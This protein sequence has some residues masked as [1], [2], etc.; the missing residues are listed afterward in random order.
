ME[1]KAPELTAKEDAI[2][3]DEELKNV[4]DGAWVEWGVV[5]TFD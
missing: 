3:S 1:N 5:S 2:V 4:A